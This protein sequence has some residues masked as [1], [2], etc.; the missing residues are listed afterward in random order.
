MFWGEQVAYRRLLLFP[1]AVLVWCGPIGEPRL[2]TH[3]GDN[4][5]GVAGV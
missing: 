1:W 3:K 2:S 5:A 4:R